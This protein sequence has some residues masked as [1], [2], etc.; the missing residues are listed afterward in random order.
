MG[1]SS[2]SSINVLFE[3]KKQL[4]D[5]LIDWLF[6]WLIGIK[7]PLVLKIGGEDGKN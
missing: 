7:L 4:I 2:G 6:V 1:T 3:D 5:W